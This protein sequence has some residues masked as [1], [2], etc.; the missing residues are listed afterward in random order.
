MKIKGREEFTAALV[1][2]RDHCEERAIWA[3]REHPRMPIDHSNNGQ[4]NAFEKGYM[5][6]IQEVNDELVIELEELI[7]ATMNLEATDNGGG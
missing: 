1:L 3:A 5:K 2:L 4:V 6:T 7:E